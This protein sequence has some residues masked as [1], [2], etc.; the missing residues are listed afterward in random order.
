[1][2][3][4]KRE[5]MRLEVEKLVKTKFVKELAYSE[6]LANPVLIKKSN[7]KYRMC[8]N[9][10]DLNQACPKNC[11]LLPDINK[12][13]DATT[14]F[15][16]LSSLDG[17]SGY[18]QIPMHKADEEKTS[19][20]TEDG[21]YCYWTMPFGFKNAGATYQ[22]LMNKIFKDQ[23]GRNI[24]VYMDDI[25]IKSRSFEEHIEDLKEI[26]AVLDKYRM[27]L[28]PAKCAFFFKEENF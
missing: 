26:F 16:Y 22:Q 5:A 24:E 10:T 1:M 14:G 2:G 13:I 12:L 23:I 11:Y 4:K 25:I 28:N 8:I 18:H 9:F 21:T 7:E 20:I 15:E 17:M 19:F 3:Q 27:K 6:L